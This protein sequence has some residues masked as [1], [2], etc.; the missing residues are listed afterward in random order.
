MFSTKILQVIGKSYILIVKNNDNGRFLIFFVFIVVFPLELETRFYYL[1]ITITTET[2]PPLMGFSR[3][4]SIT[5][6]ILKLSLTAWSE[7]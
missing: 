7:K 2:S 5:F 4:N 3:I 6:L 1:S